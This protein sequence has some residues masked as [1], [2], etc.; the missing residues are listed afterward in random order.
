M[1]DK[2]PP[3]IKGR[4]PG[5]WVQGPKVPWGPGD[6]VPGSRGTGGWDGKGLGQGWGGGDGGTGFYSKYIIFGP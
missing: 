6:R 5:S 4:A 2:G 1:R 3:G